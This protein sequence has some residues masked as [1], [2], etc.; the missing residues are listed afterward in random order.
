MS[1][2]AFDTLSVARDLE[3]AGLD[4]GPAEAIARAINHGGERAATKADLDSATA[5]LRADLDSAIAGLRADLDSATAKHRTD[6]DSAIAGLRADLDS[7]TAG[8][9]ADLD[10]AVAGLRADFYRAL[11]IQGVSIVTL[12]G[13]LIAIAAALKLL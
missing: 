6:L 12:I 11:W 4:R 3:A 7:A 10:S 13:G 5:G 9:R 8:L 1:A 2:A